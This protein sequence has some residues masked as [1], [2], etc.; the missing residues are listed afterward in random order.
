MYVWVSVCVCESKRVVCV[1]AFEKG[2]DDSNY[3]YNKFI[4]LNL[5]Q[6]VF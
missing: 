1:H 2:K 6:G 3:S 5:Q 4:D